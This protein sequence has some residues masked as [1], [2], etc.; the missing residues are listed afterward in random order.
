LTSSP[1]YSSYKY[2]GAPPAEGVKRVR[3]SPL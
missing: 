3:F 1:S 2:H